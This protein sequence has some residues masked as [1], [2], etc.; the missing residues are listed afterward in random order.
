MILYFDNFFIKTLSLVSLIKL[1]RTLLSVCVVQ[2]VM[3]SFLRGYILSIL[4]NTPIFSPYANFLLYLMISIEFERV[5]TTLG[6][7]TQ[8][9]P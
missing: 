9:Q 5:R 7:H 1:M 8:M 2:K 6:S 3:F 4:V